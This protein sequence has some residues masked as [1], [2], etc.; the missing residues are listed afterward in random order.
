MKDFW[1]FFFDPDLVKPA[2]LVFIYLFIK[3]FLRLDLF[4]TFI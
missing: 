4:I 2:P 3:I 1:K